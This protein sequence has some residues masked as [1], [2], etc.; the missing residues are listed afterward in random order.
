MSIDVD[1]SRYLAPGDMVVWGQGP[2]E[3]ATLVRALVAA[4][5]RVG[6]LRCF[7]G[8]PSAAPLLPEHVDGLGLVS[9]CGAG[10]NRA[11]HHAG[12][13]DVLPC[14]YSTFPRVLSS[15]PLKADVVLLHV[16]A[17]APDGSFG[18]GLSCEYL[19]AA[20]GSARRVLV[21]VN[22][23]LPD[24]TGGPRLSPAD[25]VVVG[26]FPRPLADPPARRAGDTEAAVA[27]RVL[28]LVPDG[29]TVQFGLG[30][31]PSAVAARLGGHRRLGVHSGMIGDEVVDLV[32]SGAVTN[33]CKSVDRGVTVTGLFT[34]SGRTAAEVHRNP[35]IQLRPTD[36]T[37]DAA[38]LAALPA[39]H[40]INSAIEVDLTGQ[41]NAEGVAG[42]Y[43]G[44][45]GGA[46]DFFRAAAISPGGAPIVVLPAAAGARSR[47][48]AEL[49]GPVSTARSDAGVI[50]TEYGV[51][52]LRGLTTGQRREALLR[53]AAPEHR[54]QLEAA[55]RS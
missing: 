6:P 37:H 42:R 12:L 20:V 30:A 39:F 18:Y 5:H 55:A 11:L 14:H 31:L 4:R 53:I 9:Y 41:V 40:A 17:P 49:S 7:V 48:V 32:R 21:E 13:L 54:D 10:G 36:Y 26:T 46:V 33:E 52:D 3:P 38:V 47:I 19:P 27:E 15:G 8:I 44:A 45:V 25:V 2:A 23:C 16:P 43:V 28:D 51:A 22:P 29:A 35:A 1:I 34:G 24:I 50:V